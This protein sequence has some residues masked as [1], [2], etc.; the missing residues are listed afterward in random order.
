M[1]NPLAK[2]L[3]LASSVIAAA[4]LSST[5]AAQGETFITEELTKWSMSGDFRFRLESNDNSSAVDRHRQ[6]M[7]FR[8]GAKYQFNE[9]VLL[10]VRGTTGNPDD[11]NS[12]HVDIGNVFNSFDFSID[13][14]Y[15]EY[16]PEEV[17]GLKV[18]GGK[19]ASPITRNPVYGEVLWDADV[20]PEGLALVYGCDDGCGIFSSMRLYGAQLAVLEQG[21]GEEAWASLVGLDLSKQT[22]DSSSVMFGMSYSFF[23][24]LTPDGS[25]GQITGDLSGNAMVGSELA[26][27]YGIL[28]VVAAWNV[29]DPVFSAEMINNLRAADDVGDSGLVLGAAVKT[30]NGKFYYSFINVEQDAVLTAFAQDDFLFATNHDSHVVGWKLPL[31]ENS[32][33]HVWAMASAPNDP[34]VTTAVDDTV[35]RFRVDWNLNF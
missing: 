5:A 9:R 16:T 22:G 23:G 4:A 20:Q 35:Y 14:L 34:D 26:S 8:L 30:D 11:P 32:G 12:P 3:L 28:D 1:N 24:D 19:F 18:I 7:R 17:A 33:L 29:S 21:G 2:P 25:T 15:F 27:D 10:G 6:R 31:T 13:R